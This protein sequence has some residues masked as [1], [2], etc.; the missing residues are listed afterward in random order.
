MKYKYGCEKQ[1][2]RKHNSVHFLSDV[3]IG[4]IWIGLRRFDE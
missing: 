2:Y 1:N 3:V 4:E